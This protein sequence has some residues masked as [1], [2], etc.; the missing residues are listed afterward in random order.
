[1]AR[2]VVLFVFGGL[3]LVIGA[4]AAIGGGALMALFGSNN[5]LSSGTQQVSTSTRALV[6]Q[7]GSIQGASGAQTAV[8]S[9]RL[10]ITA[11]PT[12]TG[13]LL[14]LGIGPAGAV[15]RYLSGVSHDVATD[16]SVA[17]FRLTL[18]RHGGTAAPPPPGSQSFWVARA[19]GTH[20]TLTWTVTDGSYR[21]VVM[22]TDA[23][24]PVAFAGGLDLTIPHSFAIGIGLLI[25]GI[26]LILIAIALIVLGARTRPRPQ[27]RPGPDPATGA[28]ARPGRTGRCRAQGAGYRRGLI[29][30]ASY[31]LR[32]VSRYVAHGVKVRASFK[33]ARRY[34]CSSLAVNGRSGASRGHVSVMPTPGYRWRGVFER[35]SA[36]Q[37]VSWPVT[38]C[39]SPGQFRS[40]WCLARPRCSLFW[41]RSGTR[42]ARRGGGVRPDRGRPGPGA[43]PRRMGLRC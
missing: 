37:V 24:A 35:P 42:M 23:A 17:P 22:N 39:R 19:S 20:P 15:D 40:P 13:H 12:G 38:N 2:R 34:W 9:V 6:S 26:V 11:T 5:T 16:V 43:G 3:L 1:M 29:K 18:A 21:L 27:S 14:F 28:L 31:A 8:G 33:F 7:A 36:F 10:R 25:G 32:G 41:P 30:L 4:L